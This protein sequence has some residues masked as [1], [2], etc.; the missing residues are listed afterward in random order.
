MPT[1]VDSGIVMGKAG[2]EGVVSSCGGGEGCV[3]EDSLS[4]DRSLT[5]I[6]MVSSA[7]AEEALEMAEEMEEM[8]EMLLERMMTTAVLQQ[9]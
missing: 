3:G 7:S 9:R 8:E 1:V 5:K 2:R 4:P 6:C